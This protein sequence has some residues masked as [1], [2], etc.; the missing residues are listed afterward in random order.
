MRQ[1]E[2]IIMNSHWERGCEDD[3]DDVSVQRTD[4]DTHPYD[5]VVPARL[6]CVGGL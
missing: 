6:F 1:L 5:I 4:K 2:G 3:D